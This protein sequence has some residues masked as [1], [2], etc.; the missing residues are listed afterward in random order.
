VVL[1]ATQLHPARATDTSWEGTEDGETAIDEE[2]ELVG[3]GR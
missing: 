3:A 1:A 2:G